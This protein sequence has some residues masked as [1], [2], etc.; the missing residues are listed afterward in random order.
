[1]ANWSRNRL[2]KNGRKI[3]LQAEAGQT[4]TIT[5]MKLGNGN[6]TINNADERTDLISPKYEA[7]ISSRTVENGVCVIHGVV[8]SKFAEED[9]YAREW[10]IFAI[11][12]DTNKEVLYAYCIDDKPDWVP[13][14]DINSLITAQYFLDLVV[15]NC[16]DIKIEVSP[17]AL[18]TVEMVRRATDT[19]E[20]F[21]EYR[22]GD[23]VHDDQLRPGQKL[24][25]I[26]GGT[27]SQFEL[28]IKNPYL[29]S[30]V[31]DGTVIWQIITYAN[32]EGDC[33]T[34]DSTGNLRVSI[35]KPNRGDPVLF[36]L[37]NDSNTLKVANRFFYSWQHMYDEHGNVVP[38]SE[39]YV[40]GVGP[41]S[42]E[43]EDTVTPAEALALYEQLKVQVQG[44]N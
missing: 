24:K 30:I 43:D 5:K 26:Q 25:C 10:G 11:D 44:K 29:N 34:R 9:F 18:A 38:R 28:I 17:H 6:L 35:P 40:G 33:F 4:L 22:T 8:A 1:M 12:N 16:A 20:R 15:S 3:L 19:L 39:H 21:T 27:T 2:T 13:S 41:S 42:S 37:D 32:F 23:I 7:A 31:N 36:V 14:A